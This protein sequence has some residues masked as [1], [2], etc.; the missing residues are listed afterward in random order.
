VV[1]ALQAPLAVEKNSDR[2]ET[3]IMRA[4]PQRLLA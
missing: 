3:Q 1:E 4:W 2:V